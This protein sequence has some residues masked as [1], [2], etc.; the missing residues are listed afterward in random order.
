MAYGY[1]TNGKAVSDMIGQ[2]DIHVEDFRMNDLLHM[3]QSA[4]RILVG[5]MTYELAYAL[6]QE[7]GITE[8]NGEQLMD[9][10]MLDF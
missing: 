9:S 3:E 10:E 6:K 1:L 5:Y 8:E 4:K 2:N 7:F